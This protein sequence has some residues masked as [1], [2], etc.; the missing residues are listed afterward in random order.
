[1]T[2]SRE[3]IAYLLAHLG[4]YVVS[5]V[6]SQIVL[7]PAMVASGMVRSQVSMYAVFFLL[8]VVVQV[9]VFFAFIAIRGRRAAN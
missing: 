1:M 4:G 2:S 3:V 7:I 8:Y 9:G 6:L 5:T